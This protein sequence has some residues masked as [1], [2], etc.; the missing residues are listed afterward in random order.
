[1]EKFGTRCPGVTRQQKKR[2]WT[3]RDLVDFEVLLDKAALWKDAWR[4]GV[5]EA[6]ERDGARK[7][8]VRRRLGFRWMLEEIRNREGEQTG[9]RVESGARLLAFLLWLVMLLVGVGVLRGLL[10][11]FE[12]TRAGET[13]TMRGYNIW[14]LLG[15]T[16][17]FQWLVMIGA[18]LAYWLWRRWSGSLGVLQTLLRKIIRKWGGKK[19][20]G[21][22]WQR[23]QTRVSGGQSVLSWRLARVLQAGGVGYNCGLL[24]GLFGCLWF[25]QI[26]FYWE[27]TLPQF[28]RDSLAGVTEFLALGVNGLA[29]SMPDI[30]QA[31][32]GAALVQPELSSFPRRTLIDLR[33]GFFFLFAIAVWGL[34]PRVLLWLAAW[35]MERRALAGLDFQEARHRTLWRDLTKVCRG[36]VRSGPADGVVLLDIGGLEMETEAM[37]PFLLQSLRVNPEARFS[38]GTLDAE[39]EKLALKTAGAAAMGVVFLV[40]G[41]NLSPKQMEVYHSQV[42]AA[43]GDDPMIRYVVVGS[44]EELG[45]WQTFVDSLRDSETA[46]VR[47]HAAG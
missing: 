42:R 22:V 46:V 21:D 34:L 33:W 3:L 44:E 47:F 43:I 12:Y 26:G 17:G 41:W 37:R 6:L 25:F 23:L 20:A 32:R 30:D 4:Q 19:M 7:E 8:L 18:A 28:G 14:I 9:E 15:V 36:E 40:E 38:L 24:L 39:Q 10:M 27:S 13:V 29:P 11:E 5:G 45:Q 2:T 35:R 31:K 1:M 16:L